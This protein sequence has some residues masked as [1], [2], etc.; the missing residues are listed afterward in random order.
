[1]AMR[2]L[3]KQEFEQELE[4]AGLVKTDLVTATS[5]LWRAPNGRHMTIPDLCQYP[6]SILEDVLR[7]LGLLYRKPN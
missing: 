2:L 1:M 5:R 4:R 6:D 3:T 7:Q